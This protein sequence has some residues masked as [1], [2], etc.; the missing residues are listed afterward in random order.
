MDHP[1]LIYYNDAHH[2]HGKRIEPPTSRHMLQWPVDELA[3]T[4][5]DLLVFGLG[6][7]DVYF[8]DSEVGRVVGQDKEVW[9]SFIDWRVMRMVEEARRLGTDQLREVIER[10][11]ELGLPVFPSLKLQ[12]VA[13]PGGERCGRLKWERGEVVCLG[14]EGRYEFAYD[15]ALDEVR[16][17]KLAMVREVLEEYRADG[18]ELDFMFDQCYFRPGQVE[19]GTQI[20]SEFVAQV[21]QLARD[22]G[23]VQHRQICVMVRVALEREHNLAMGLDVEGWLAA[24]HVDF[25]AG[26]D[27]RILT[28]TEPKPAWLPSAANAAEGAAYYRPPRR[29]YHESVGSPSLE[30]CRAL[31]QTLAR[32]G[33]AGLYHGYMPWPLAEREY[34]CLREMAYPEVTERR[35]KRYYLQPREGAA[36]DATSTPERVLPAELDM[37]R[38]IE[39][40]IWVADDVEGARRDNEMRAANLTLRFAAY[41]VDDEVEMRFN[42]RVLDQAAAEV[43]H[44]RALTM[45]TR[46]AGGME[47]DA[48]LGMPAH[49]FRFRLEPDAVRPGRNL[50]EVECRRLD[51]R[52]GFARSLNGV[53]LHLRYR[54]FER[55]LGLEVERV[56][57]PSG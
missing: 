3:G 12:D 28:D 31:R 56:D 41:C 20:M 14:M 51:P 6:Y 2:F 25:V 4:G 43:T 44:E 21:R 54:D 22:I 5:V 40:E 37:E 24:G 13:P 27:E 16:E 9:E 11:T 50:V 30:M 57:P 34:A 42:G 48:P 19:E 52:A 26:Q 10:G 23:E 32:Q 18:I 35:P 33:Y 39:A 49:W 45:A 46:L 17:S 55:P 29:V 38:V 47:I 1:R 53:E 15:W 36:G 8:H 7:G